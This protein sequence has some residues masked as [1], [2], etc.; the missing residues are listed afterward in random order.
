MKRK[1][2]TFRIF[3]STFLLGFVLCFVSVSVF[4]SKM[5]VYFE[6][7]IFSELR[8]ESCFLEHYVLSGEL[9]SVLSIETANRMT[10]VGADGT[11]YFDNKVPHTSLGNHSSREEIELARKNGSVQLSRFSDTL[12][13]KTLYFARLLSNGDVVR[14]SCSKHSVWALLFGMGKYLLVIF[15]VGIAFFAF[16]SFLIS[17]KIVNPLNKIDLENPDAADV[18]DELKPF[19]RRIAEDNFEKSQR[20]ELRKQFSANVSHELKTPLTSISGFAEILKEGGTDEETTKDFASSIYDESQR[21][22]SLVNDI[23]R[24]SKLDEKSICLEKSVFSLLDVCR[25]VVESLS[26]CAERKGV[27]VSVSGDSGTMAGVEPVIDELVYNLV[28]NAIKY[29][30]QD[31]KVDISVESAPGGKTVVLKVSDTGIG[32]EKRDLERIFERFYRVD[33][34]RSKRNGG[35]GLGL[36]IVKHAAKYHGATVSV[37]SELGRGSV[38]TVEFCRFSGAAGS[39]GSQ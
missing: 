27:A 15:S 5:Y 38:F 28:D 20:E 3:M 7:Q 17:R 30:V 24:L 36:S 23:I 16:F 33:K 35:T 21:M 6:N 14:I 25:E 19:V 2:L 39:A 8:T 4:V 12:A 22:I 18:Y 29:N 11:V 26:L 37:E 9:S 32:I 1:S 34:S 10:V 13:E 31:G